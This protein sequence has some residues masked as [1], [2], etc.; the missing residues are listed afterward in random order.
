MMM[1]MLMTLLDDVYGSFLT[2]FW[3]DGDVD[4]V[5]ETL[6]RKKKR[7]TRSLGKDALAHTFLEL[8]PH[9]FLVLKPGEMR[10]YFTR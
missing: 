3:C 8:K 2:M 7:K 4:D 6:V 9:T 5:N 10:D 1:L